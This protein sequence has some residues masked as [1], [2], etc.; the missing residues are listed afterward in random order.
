[1]VWGRMFPRVW[2]VEV[3]RAVR[4]DAV[5]LARSSDRPLRQVARELGVNHE[6][7]H[8]W[9]RTAEQTQPR[10]A[11]TA[12][13]VDQEELRSLRKAAAKICLGARA[14]F[15]RLPPLLHSAD[16]NLTYPA[17]SNAGALRGGDWERADAL[18]LPERWPTTHNRPAL[19]CRGPVS[20]GQRSAS[21][22]VRTEA[23]NA[24][25][26]LPG[27]SAC[28]TRMHA[29]RGSSA[30]LR[31]VPEIHPFVDDPIWC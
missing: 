18:D 23:I 9:V 2:Q 3:P 30:Q 4:R 16:P 31:P 24:D 13:T 28:L 6:P 14:A 19:T 5:G 22:I 21:A 27:R 17:F 7:L 25:A 20:T 8:N 1:V 10:P 12:A 26:D 15:A 29:D 11:N